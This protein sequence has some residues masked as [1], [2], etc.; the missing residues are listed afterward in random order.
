M[1]ESCERHIMRSESCTSMPKS[2]DYYRFFPCVRKTLLRFIRE[3]RCLSV[4]STLYFC[5]W[6]QSYFLY[7]Q[8]R[9]YYSSCALFS[10]SNIFLAIHN[11]SFIF[12][13]VCYNRSHRIKWMWNFLKMIHWTH[14]SHFPHSFPKLFLI[15]SSHHS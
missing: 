15:F 13:C 2:R 7:Y 3:K 12:K 14:C 10:T 1:T 11:Y 8:H 9:M 4:R 5:A 6:D